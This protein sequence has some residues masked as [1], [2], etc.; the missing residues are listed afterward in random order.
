MQYKR[1]LIREKGKVKIPTS[2]QREKDKLKTT[3]NNGNSERENQYNVRVG[4][5]KKIKKRN[6]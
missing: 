2:S 4:I 5:T 3:L 6:F 1:K